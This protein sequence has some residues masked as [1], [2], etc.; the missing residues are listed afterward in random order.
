MFVTLWIGR[1]L[2]HT[3]F[4]ALFAQ[5]ADSSRGRGIYLLRDL[6]ELEYDVG[7]VVQ[8]YI[9]RPL[10]IGGYKLV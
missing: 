5:P 10:T 7:V 3:D 4:S 9:E 2:P 1:R 6:D 8:M